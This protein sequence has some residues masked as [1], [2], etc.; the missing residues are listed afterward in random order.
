MTKTMNSEIKVAATTTETKKIEVT[1]NV[2][3]ENKVNL[4]KADK[5]S[6]KIDIKAETKPEVK[7]E[8]PV[9]IEVKPEITIDTTI[10]ASS[11]TTIA[12]SAATLKKKS[13]GQKIRD[14]FAKLL[15]DKK[16]TA[17]VVK[18]LV[19]TEQ[20]KKVLNI[21]Y[22]FLKEATKNVDRFVVKYARYTNQII[23]VNGTKFWVTNDLYEKQ[24]PHFETWAASLYE[25]KKPEKKAETKQIKK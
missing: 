20:T 6:V 16:I 13:A 15:V 25:E 21:R 3:S 10:A 5:P 14:I 4:I 18:I 12:A 2:K 7:A 23:E 22:A 19:D 1:T 24:V 11:E 9:K 17:D 8:K